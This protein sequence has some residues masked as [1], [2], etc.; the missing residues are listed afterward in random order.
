M[1]QNKDLPPS[2]AAPVCPLPP[3]NGDL[4]DKVLQID[5]TE[6]DEGGGHPNLGNK[7][8]RKKSA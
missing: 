8:R 5:V 2:E 3:R 7:E 1:N 6:G 4:E